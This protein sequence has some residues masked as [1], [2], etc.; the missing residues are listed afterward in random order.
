MKI[1]LN[2]CYGGFSLSEYAEE[3]L[4]L[5]DG[6]YDEMEVRQDAQFIAYIEA[7]GAKRMGGYS[8]E[9]VIV[10]IPDECTDWELDE[11]DGFESIVYVVNGKLYHA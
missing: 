5:S 11:Y 7:F 3:L 9:L 1:V 8:A 4:G 6:W 10:E 2:K